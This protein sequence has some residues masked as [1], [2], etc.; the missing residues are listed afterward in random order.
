[1]KRIILFFKVFFVCLCF[2]STAKAE[3]YDSLQVYLLTC[4]PHDEIYS[5]YGHT[6]IRVVNPRNNMDIAINY[7]AFD[8]SSRNFVLRFVFGLTDYMMMV[9]S[10]SDFLAEYRYFGSAVHQQHINMSPEEKRVFM[11][12]L[13]ESAKPENITYRYNYFYNNCT[14]KA[15]DIILGAISGEKVV[16]RPA[17]D[18][19]LTYRD[20]IHI[21]TADSPWAAWGNDFLLGVL[22]DVK[23]TDYEAEFIPDRLMDDFTHTVVVDFDGNKRQLVDEDIVVLQ[24]CTPH[25]KPMEGFPLRPLTVFCI[26]SAIIVIWSMIKFIIHNSSTSEA[27]KPI[28]QF[29]IINYIDYALCCLYA[30]PGILL[31]CMLFSQHPTVSLNF[32]ILLFNPLLFWLAWPKCRVQRRWEIILGCVVLFLVLGL[33]QSYAEGVIML[34]CAL[35]CL[36]LSNIKLPPSLGKVGMGS[37]LH[38][39]FYISL[40]TFYISLASCHS[41]SRVAKD[42][43]YGVGKE[44]RYSTVATRPANTGK[45]KTDAI[46]SQAM[47]LLGAKYRSGGADTRGFDCSGFTSYVYGQNGIS[48]GRSSRDQFAQNTP[49]NRKQIRPGDLVFFSGT[50][51]GSDVGHV[52]IVTEV[53]KSADTF[54]F[55][56][57][58]SRG[59]VVISRSTDAYYAQRYLGARRVE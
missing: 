11:A 27:A 29:I 37:L 22:A 32:Q 39:T 14:T 15:R 40:F 49:I 4:E 17:T 50:R 38:F 3:S 56:H 35:G 55:I 57:S 20:L 36:A 58:S 43:V 1:V 7:G 46:L 41:S 25:F 10:Y 34:A 6:A 26:L 28:T 52:G 44:Q 24:S 47:S 12:A 9:Y 33:V 23:T 2:H 48:I 51:I 21:K 19:H 5:L 31:F 42:D 59:G 53:D 18:E 54:L 30:V 16:E 8:S 45:V 13:A